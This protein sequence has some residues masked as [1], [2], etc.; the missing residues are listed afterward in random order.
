[1]QEDRSSEGRNHFCDVFETGCELGICMKV[2]ATYHRLPKCSQQQASKRHGAPI[3]SPEILEAH[4]TY[5][6]DD[7]TNGSTVFRV[8]ELG[9]LACAA[10][11]SDWTYHSA[12][13]DTMDATTK[14]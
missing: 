2:V 1:M 5:Q 3:P 6:D 4:S 12:V 8:E 13:L 9:T 7:Q 11:N 14:T 10:G